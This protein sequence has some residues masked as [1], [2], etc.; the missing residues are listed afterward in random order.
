[1]F[2]TPAGFENLGTSARCAVQ[3]MY[4]KG[5]VFSVQGHPEF[6]EFIISEIMKKRHS[7]GTYGEGPCGDAVFN[8]GMARAPLQHDGALVASIICQ[9]FT[10]SL[11]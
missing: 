3:G 4:L 1:M 7:Q 8:D 2:E 11:E 5:K 6:D 9:F 10:G